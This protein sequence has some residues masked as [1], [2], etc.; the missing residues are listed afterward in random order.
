[1]SLSRL[2][3]LTIFEIK[4]AQGEVDNCGVLLFNEYILCEPLEVEDDIRR[5]SLQL[6]SSELACRFLKN[7]YQQ[8]LTTDQRVT[9]IPV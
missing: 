7:K 8:L 6:E 9:Q 4:A 3:G 2:V 5:K 1:M